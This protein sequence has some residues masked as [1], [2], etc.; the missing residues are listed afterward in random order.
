VGALLED[1]QYHRIT[2]IRIE[3]HTYI[4]EPLIKK[5]SVKHRATLIMVKDGKELGR[6]L[7]SSK[8]DDIEQLFNKSIY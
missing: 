3:Y 7:W 4:N 5:W 6:V 1:G 8:K 2:V